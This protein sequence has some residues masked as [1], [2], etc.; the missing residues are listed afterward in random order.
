M[1]FVLR[2]EY[3]PAVFG[4]KQAVQFKKHCR[5]LTGTLPACAVL[6][7]G[8]DGEYVEITSSSD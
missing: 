7:D 3:H 1:E 5:Q 8:K 4:D 2:S 6:L